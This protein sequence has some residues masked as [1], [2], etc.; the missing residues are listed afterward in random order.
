VTFSYSTAGKKTFTI[1]VFVH[2]PN[3]KVLFHLSKDVPS[4]PIPYAKQ[5]EQTFL[6]SHAD[7]PFFL[8]FSCLA[9]GVHN[10]SM[11][12]KYKDKMTNLSFVKECG[13]ISN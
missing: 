4:D 11:D 6:V 10:V 7:K 12:F 1:D 13:K 8:M 2:T 9:D 5:I 3:E